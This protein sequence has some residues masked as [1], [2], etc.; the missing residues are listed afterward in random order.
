MVSDTSRPEKVNLYILLS[1]KEKCQKKECLNKAKSR[2][3][4]ER[5]HIYYKLHI[6]I[7]VLPLGCLAIDS[8]QSGEITNMDY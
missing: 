8:N 4:K 2:K 1:R 6:F 7:A 5:L 3:A